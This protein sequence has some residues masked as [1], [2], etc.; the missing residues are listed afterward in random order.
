MADE[1]QKRLVA[2]A[3]E[4]D[5]NRAVMSWIN[6][7]PDIPDIITVINYSLYQVTAAGQP[8]TP[9][10]RLMLTQGTYIVSQDILGGHVADYQF[11]ICYCG[12]F[13]SNGERLD[14]DEMLNAIGD[15][16][17]ENPPTLG[18]RIHVQKVEVSARA[19]YADT[20]EDNGGEEHQILMHMTYEVK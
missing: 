19:A 20:Y 3:E 1:K 11:A 8:I 7:A 17:V 18:E 6:N 15:W 13:S 2:A 10:M 5:I 12:K 9:N 14:A 16:A 4:R